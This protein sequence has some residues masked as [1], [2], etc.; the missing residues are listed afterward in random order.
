MPDHRRSFAPG[1]C[2]P[3]GRFGR[4]IGWADAAR[5]AIIGGLAGLAVLQGAH[6]AGAQTVP[7]PPRGSP[8]P[9][10]LQPEPP[11]VSPGAAAPAPASPASVNP[12]LTT[13]V[14][15]VSVQGAT[16][17]PNDVLL[18]LASG[19]TGPAVQLSRIEA[20]RTAIVNRYRGD[21]YVYTAVHVRVHDGHLLLIVTEGR[22]VDVKLDGNIGPAGTQVLRFLHRLTDIQPLTNAALERAL[23]LASDVPG[24]TIHAVINP[25]NTDP[26]ALTLVAQVSRQPVSA[27][28]SADNRAFRQT[29]PEE[30]LALTDFNSL[31]S[32]GERTEISIYHTFD[33]TDTFGQASEEF[34]IGSSG[35]K[36]RIYGGAGESVPSGS[37]RR[38]GYDGVTRVFGAA[39]TYPVIRSRQQ[40][41]TVSGLFDG[42][43]SDIS[44]ATSGPPR[45]ASFDSLRV[46]RAEADDVLYDVWLGPSLGATD[47]GSVRVSQGLPILGASSNGSPGVPRLHEEVDFTKVNA[48]LDR[49]QYLF[50][51]GRSASVSLKLAAA[52][53]YSGNVLP[54][55]EQFYLGGPHFNRGFYYGEVTGDKAA[56]ATFEPVFDTALPSVPFVSLRL[57]AEFYGFYDWGEVWQN[58]SLDLNHTLRSTGGG[59]RLYA[60]GRAEID[61]EGVS[62]LTRTPNGAPPEVSR[63]KS[64]AFYWQVLARF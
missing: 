44:N 21:G 12:A 56:T 64:S 32:L 27:Q 43:E 61:L 40:T 23:L 13:P 18:S 53:Q 26:G 34:F 33:N 2:R 59:V 48:E 15:D 62:R 46:L 57:R 3:Q 19:L 38:I 52:G 22:I 35:L 7:L 24:I 16:A 55:E 28:I 45:R 14:N 29:G 30:L 11:A 10:V 37:L 63:L 8:L 1:V 49:T 20:A 39:V 51:V 60:G 31:T 47:L 54:P 6:D 5:N 50:P 9:G 4:R 41:L 42:V 36:L 25:S 17:Y 58:Q